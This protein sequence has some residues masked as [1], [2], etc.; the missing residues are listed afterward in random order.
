MKELKNIL[1]TFIF[2]LTLFNCSYVFAEKNQVTFQEYAIEFISNTITSQNY[3]LENTESKLIYDEVELNKKVYKKPSEEYSFIKDY[4]LH[5]IYRIY[6]NAIFLYY[7]EYE[8][9]NEELKMVDNNSLIF[10]NTD[11]FIGYY[12]YNGIIKYSEDIYDEFVKAK[13][14]GVP[15]NRLLYNENGKLIGY[16]DNKGNSYAFNDEM[17]GQFRCD[18]E[19]RKNN[20]N[21]WKLYFFTTFGE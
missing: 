15:K 16:K 12:K 8:E 9:V 5:S 3:F 19:F 6:K 18:L 10:D 13:T 1:Q 2:I 14:K 20:M 4:M 17:I 7:I 21:E 11:R